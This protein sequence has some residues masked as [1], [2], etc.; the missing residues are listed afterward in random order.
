MKCIDALEGTIKSIL[1][2]LHHICIE[3]R[4]DDSEYV[5]NV[6]AVISATDQYL[7][8]NPEL[9]EDTQLFGKVLYQHA[10]N[11]WLQGQLAAD[12]A[13]D[14]AE[15]MTEE[16]EEYQTYYFDYLYNRGVYPC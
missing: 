11:L 15:Q 7:L 14:P 12:Q 6:K 2:Q 1:T 3:D 10:R 9:V 16:K 5:R 8:N 13:V 4:L